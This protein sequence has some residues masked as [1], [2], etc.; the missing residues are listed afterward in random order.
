MQ[1]WRQKRK[2]RNADFILIARRA[3]PYPLNPVNLLNPLNPFSKSTPLSSVACGATSFLWK[4]A[5]ALRH[6]ALV[7]QK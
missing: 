4:G 6:T 1:Q 5:L 3:I 7:I 2:S